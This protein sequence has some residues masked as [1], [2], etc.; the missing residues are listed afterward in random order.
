MKASIKYAENSKL[1]LLKVETFD[2][3]MEY[4]K[5]CRKF[6]DKYYRED[7]QCV[8]V[9]GIVYPVDSCKI[10]YDYDSKSYKYKVPNILFGVVAIENGEFIRGYFIPNF[11]K[12][13]T[14]IYINS[15]GDRITDACMSYHIPKSLGYKEHI[16]E[17][18]WAAPECLK[19]EIEPQLLDYANYRI[20][21]HLK[22]CFVI[23][24]DFDKIKQYQFKENAYNAEESKDFEGAIKQ[25]ES[26]VI[27]YDNKCRMAAKL[28]GD[29]TI[30]CEVEVKAGCIPSYIRSE[31]GVIICKDGSIGYTPEFVT[32]PYKGAKGL[33]SLK[34]LFLELNERCNT[35]HTCSLH[36]H[37][38]NTRTDRE[39]I[40][41]LF[42][43]FCDV[44][45][46]LYK[47][48]PWYKTDPT[49]VTKDN[50]NYSAM[51]PY[52]IIKGQ[53]L[54]SEPYRE[55]V[56]KTYRI[57]E[58]WLME[59]KSPGK[60]FNRKNGIHPKGDKKWDRNKRYVGLNFMNMFF[61]KRNTLE[62]RSHHSVLNHTKA[63]NWLF[64]CNAILKYAE[65]NSGR[66][67][68]D[69]MKTISLESVLN[70]YKDNFKTSYA[71]SVSEYLI[72]YY[73]SRVITFA[74][75][76]AKGDYGAQDDYGQKIYSFEHQ[77]MSDL[78]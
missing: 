38:G 11:S 59:V 31:L 65:V 37:F 76:K 57:I 19:A 28:L 25:Y 6:G 56:N 32:V 62:F 27:S 78:F 74:D 3:S 13:C 41:A 16:N 40:V 55:R 26:S 63:I 77:G 66:I 43:V 18:Q 22:N 61:S 14:V 23:A 4:K 24:E 44:Q 7:D 75:L 9:M 48:L 51:L 45:K 47:M 50:K 36:Y 49:G 30:G 72:A 39:Y 68:V 52:G 29:T 69:P 15:K 8:I 5:N 73:K 2:G 1:K 46:N 42:K 64:I 12:N 53:L 70:Y 58:M 60:D 10:F 35:N 33:Q 54:S 71:T 67:M 21:K 34:N 20:K 17:A